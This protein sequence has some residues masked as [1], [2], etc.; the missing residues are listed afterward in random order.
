MTVRYSSSQP[1]AARRL[2]HL[3]NLSCFQLPDILNP[4]GFERSM[5]KSNKSNNYSHEKE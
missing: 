5:D 4:I 2:G 1:R 3:R